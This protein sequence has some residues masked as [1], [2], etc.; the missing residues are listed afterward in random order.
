MVDLSGLQDV[1]LGEWLRTEVRDPR[2]IELVLAMVRVTTYSDEPDRQSAAALGQL[3]LNLTGSALV[4][5]MG[6]AGRALRM[7]ATSSGATWSPDGAWCR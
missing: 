5:W 2:V 1:S 6:H 3:T 7:V 4:S